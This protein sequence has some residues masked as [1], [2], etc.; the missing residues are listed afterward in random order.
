MAAASRAQQGSQPRAKLAA[1]FGRQLAPLPPTRRRTPDFAAIADVVGSDDQVLHDDIFV[2]DEDRVGRQ[3]SLIDGTEDVPIHA[4]RAK[5]AAIS[6]WP[7]LGFFA[8]PCPSFLLR[9]VIAW[10]RRGWRCC[11]RCGTDGGRDAGPALEF[12]QAF[13]KACILRGQPIDFVADF[14]D[15]IEHLARDRA[16]MSIRQAIH[17]KPHLPHELEEFGIHDT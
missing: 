12:P 7:P 16:Q 5:R 8:L 1:D 10:G 2:T 15:Q 4:D 14:F 3:G 6:A 9:G 11:Q 17:V 13:A